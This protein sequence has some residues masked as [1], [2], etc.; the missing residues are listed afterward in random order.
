MLAKL[1]SAP[2]LSNLQ[3]VPQVP[4][5]LPYALIPE[6]NSNIKIPYKTKERSAMIMGPFYKINIPNVRN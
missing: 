1:R 3:K 4:V 6:I 2:L 5:L